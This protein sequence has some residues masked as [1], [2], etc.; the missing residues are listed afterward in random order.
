MFAGMLELLGRYG[1]MQGGAGSMSHVH[2][3]R[4]APCIT[5]GTGCCTFTYSLVAACHC[6]RMFVAFL[7]VEVARET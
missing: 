4:R 7:H 5:L 6:V 3:G 1:I 2:Q